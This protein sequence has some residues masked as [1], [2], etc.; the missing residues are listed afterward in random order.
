MKFNVPGKAFAAQLQ[1]VS[2]VISAKNTIS[3]LDNFLLTLSGDRLY[4]KGSDSENVFQA[5]LE[6]FDAQGEGSI[7][8]NSKR[9]LEVSKEV[10]SQPLTVEVDEESCNVK[11]S[12]PSGQ[13]SFV[14]INAAEYPRKKDEEMEK[15]N[16]S[17]PAKVVQKGIDATLF[18]VSA[19]PIRPIMTGILW[20]FKTDNM[21]FVSTDTH[22]LVKYVNRSVAPD[23]EHQ[24]V[25]PAKPATIL[26]SVLSEDDVMVDVEGDAKK[27]LFRFGGYE[28]SSKLVKG[29]FPDYN[30]VIPQNNPFRL[31][32]DRNTLLTA[33]RRVSI[34]A[35]PASGLV[36]LGLSDTDIELKAQDLDSFTD[37]CEH[38]TCHYEGN[39]MNI[40]FKAENM[41]NVLTNLKGD[42]V[43]VLLSDPARPGLFMPEEKNENEETIMLQMPMQVFE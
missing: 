3:I 30:R 38:V 32:V 37:A 6:V 4:I 35:N 28:L 10:S 16:I 20:D 11:I 24:F 19:D 14:G 23:M 31:S 9:L 29:K 36:R 42:D 27:V 33:V 39:P 22:I 13:F 43:L 15:F 8:L 25:L 1:A 40:G 7:A 5:T 12:F 41:K 26:R 21:T 2:K 17:I 34:F 18:A